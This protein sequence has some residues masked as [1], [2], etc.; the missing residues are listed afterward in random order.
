MKIQ[1]RNVGLSTYQGKSVHPSTGGLNERRSAIHPRLRR[2]MSE[3]PVARSF[4]PLANHSS[5]PSVSV[6]SNFRP[7]FVQ[8]SGR[9]DLR[10]PLQLNLQPPSIRITGHSSFKPPAVHL[11]KL[12]V[13]VCLNLRPHSFESHVESPAAVHFTLWPPPVCLNLRPPFIRVSGCRSF[14]PPAAACSSNLLPPFVR[15][16]GC[17]FIGIFGSRSFNLIN[18][19][20]RHCELL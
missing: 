11:S 7:P 19:G 2:H 16:S 18:F 17:P 10:L 12:P 9:L 8:N 5:E 4:E 3:S 6:R 13:A 20:T 14:E 1:S 15:I